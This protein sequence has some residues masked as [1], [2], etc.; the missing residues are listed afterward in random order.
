VSIFE[1]SAS[2]T[3]IWNYSKHRFEN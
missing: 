3:H 1:T 2:T